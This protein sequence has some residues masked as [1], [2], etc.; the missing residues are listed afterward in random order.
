MAGWL[1][2]W[3]HKRSASSALLDVYVG[4]RR[5]FLQPNGY[6]LRTALASLRAAGVRYRVLDRVDPDALGQCAFMHVDLSELP[7]PFDRV[8]ALYPRCIN[9]RA[10]T[11]CRRRY[12]RALLTQDAAYDGPV[13][14]KSALN[15]RGLPELRFA[16]RRGMMVSPRGASRRRLRERWCPEYR[17]FASASEVPDDAW[18]D[19]A[20]IVER[21][22]PG[23]LE[24]PVVKHRH[25]FMLDLELNTRATFDSLLCL[26]ETVR[27][28]EFIDS[29]PDEVHRVRRELGLD[30]GSID[31]FMVD[32]EAWVVDANKTTTC[33]ASWV[34]AH[35]P[36]RSYLAA[37]AQRLERFAHAG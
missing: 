23:R 7:S 12:S 2:A 27:R 6:I 22:L 20:L 31:Y 14:V 9:G 29:A 15:H 26:P 16:Q 8:H 18:E 24:R 30:Y 10:T 25:D 33:T 11:I 37:V 35:P 21:F 32:G 28:V 19:P 3:W 13:I 4:W 36:L 5:D 34:A 1:N 17:L